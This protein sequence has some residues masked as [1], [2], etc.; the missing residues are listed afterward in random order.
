VCLHDFLSSYKHFT[1]MSVKYENKITVYQ[2]QLIYVT[3]RCETQLY[4]ST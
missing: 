3:G 4:H 1:H 2:M